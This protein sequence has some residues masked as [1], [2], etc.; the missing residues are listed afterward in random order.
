MGSRLQLRD[1]L[2]FGKREKSFDESGMKIEIATC[3]NGQTA[4]NK[5]SEHL[6]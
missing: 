5:A 2:G 6:S 3:D 4:G 1:D